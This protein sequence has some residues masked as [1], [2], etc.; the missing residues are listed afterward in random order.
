DRWSAAR[1]VCELSFRVKSQIDAY[2][3]QFDIVSE[4]LKRPF[5]ELGLSS[6]VEL[7][8]KATARLMAEYVN[9]LEYT[10]GSW[11][12]GI[13]YARDMYDAARADVDGFESIAAAEHVQDGGAL[14]A[15]LSRPSTPRTPLSLSRREADLAS[16]PRMRAIGRLRENMPPAPND[17][18]EREYHSFA[19]VMEMADDFIRELEENAKAD[20]AIRKKA[21]AG[22]VG[23]SP[24]ELAHMLNLPTVPLTPGRAAT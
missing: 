10:E 2:L 22:L 21:D 11:V 9:G 20:A 23:M 1:L 7:Q 4:L 6:E 16:Q 8:R 14:G 3:D 19:D 12:K 13:E 15:Q 18:D 24:Q 17:V 5:P